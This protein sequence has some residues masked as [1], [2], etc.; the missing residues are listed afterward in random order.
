MLFHMIL[1]SAEYINNKKEK[2]I[3]NMKLLSLLI[4]SVLLTG[5]NNGNDKKEYVSDTDNPVINPTDPTNPDVTDP[6]DPDITDPDGAE[7]PTP[8]ESPVRVDVTPI[9]PDSLTATGVSNPINSIANDFYGRDEGSSLEL[10]REVCSEGGLAAPCLD[11]NGQNLASP[12]LSMS[13]FSNVVDVYQ[14][15]DFGLDFHVATFESPSDSLIDDHKMA[16]YIFDNLIDDT[17]NN[18]SV[19]RLASLLELSGNEHLLSRMDIGSA[20]VNAI[21]AKEYVDY[22]DNGTAPVILSSSVYDGFPD[23]A[24]TSS[25]TFNS[26]LNRVFSDYT[27]ENYQNLIDLAHN[28]YYSNRSIY[29]D[30][31]THNELGVIFPKN[32]EL[33]AMAES[34]GRYKM[35][36]SLLTQQYPK[37]EVK[38]S[39][40]DMAS[41]LDSY[42]T[43]KNID[44]GKFSNNTQIDGDPLLV[45]HR[46]TKNY[47]AQF[48]LLNEIYNWNED[49]GANFSIEDLRDGKY[50]AI[51]HGF[52]QYFADQNYANP[53][54]DNKCNPFALEEGEC[55]SPN[56]Y[57]SYGLL[58]EI[59][60][61]GSWGTPV[62]SNNAA[63]ELIKNLKANAFG[64]CNTTP[65]EHETS[66]DA[67]IR[68]AFDKAGFRDTNGD[69]VSIERIQNNWEQIKSDYISS[70][71][72]SDSLGTVY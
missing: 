8:E 19:T 49:W 18:Q 47:I 60:M 4:T 66:A 31:A 63:K 12:L 59:V 33:A 27:N 46:M 38:F 71:Y 68:D 48:A 72:K 14:G 51:Y 37:L 11:E 45:T 34:Y 5:C 2:I 3:M 50:R 7:R 55:T 29:E 16:N 17:T 43:T 36:G 28:A 39:S 20:H 64:I 22:R 35:N 42:V 70:G 30:I 56:N 1:S 52:A 26:I 32:K 24:L 65:F 41:E 57:G 23:D 25:N 62:E 6:T 58:Y 13:N 44:L 9:V 53:S 10:L 15:T 61:A 21:I 54:V 69:Q 67:C 40:D